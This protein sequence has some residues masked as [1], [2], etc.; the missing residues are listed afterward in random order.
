MDLRTFQQAIQKAGNKL[1]PAPIKGGKLQIEPGEQVLIK[2]WKGGSLA[3]HLQSNWKG[4]Y[5]VILAT[6]MA[7]IGI[8]SWIHHSRVKHATEE[9]TSNQTQPGDTYSCEPIKDFQEEPK[10]FNLNYKHNLYCVLL[11][12]TC[13]SLS[14]IY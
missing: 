8:D 4:P 10:D 2:S 14:P 3:V 5:P 13:T 9:S 11:G 12:Y 6:P 7:V 1:L